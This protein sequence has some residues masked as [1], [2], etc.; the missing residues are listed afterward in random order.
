MGDLERSHPIRERGVREEKAG[1]EWIAHK[2]CF[3]ASVSI[4]RNHRT[5]L[6][7][8]FVRIWPCQALPQTA[9]NDERNRSRHSLLSP[10]PE[11][12]K[13]APRWA[14]SPVM[15]QSSPAHHASCLPPFLSQPCAGI[16]HCRPHHSGPFLSLHPT[17]LPSLGQNTARKTQHTGACQSCHPPGISSTNA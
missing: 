6:S 15:G 8:P 12:P 4:E 3:L 5:S 14:P 17:K 13:R 7:E 10:T 11:F 16:C 9:R 1:R 2:G